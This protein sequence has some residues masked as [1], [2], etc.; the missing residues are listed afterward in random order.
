MD[1]RENLAWKESFFKDNFSVDQC[2]SKYTQK[3]DLETLRRDLKTY[4]ADLHQQ[5]SEIL[6]TETE[7][8]VNLAEYLTNLNSKIENLS[9][10]VNQLQEEVRT[11][12]KVIDS[13]ENEFKTMVN[14]MK[15]NNLKKNHFHLKLGII[16]SLVYIEKMLCASVDSF[17]DLFVLERIVCKYSFQCNHIFQLGLMSED[18]KDLTRNIENSLLHMVNVNFLEAVKNDDSEILTRCLRMYDNL[19]KQEEAEEILKVKVI[20]PFM[21]NIITETNLEK[22][23]QDLCQIYQQVLNFLDSKMSLLLKIIVTNPDLRS[24]KFALNSFWK[25]FDR[26]SREGLPNITAPGNP[27][28]FQKRFK[29]TWAVLLRIAEKCEDKNLIYQDT[30]FQEH[31]KRF[32]LPVYFEIRYQQIAGTFE[33]N[34]QV[35]HS[36]MYCSPNELTCKLGPT[37]GLWTAVSQCFHE[38]IYLDQLADQFLKLSMMLLSRY[39]IWFET[40]IK[41]GF[42]D[43]Q[44]EEK[45][46]M[47]SLADFRV[48]E[49]FLAADIIKF[50]DIEN[51]VFKIVHHSMSQVILR[52][53]KSNKGS[54]EKVQSHLTNHLVNI[55]F[56]NIS[57]QLQNVASI[58]RLY[59]RT[60]RS[61]PK[62]PST[63]MIEA[64]KPIIVFQETF[65]D[66]MRTKTQDI[67]NKV[68]LQVSQ[69]Y[70]SLVQGVLQSVCKTEESLRRL[71]NRTSNAGDESTPQTDSDEMKIREQIKLDVAY[72]L[73]KLCP[74]GSKD[75]KEI[76][77]KLKKEIC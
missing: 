34:I 3:S 50:S 70:F 51:T 1:P 74:L 52:V 76:M 15:N 13:I 9:L 23:N 53:L 27:E 64:L 73:D 54:I 68:I 55:K 29:S 14:E 35:D 71:K 31:L 41:A 4:G 5:M 33:N 2:L 77:D 22:L 47:D 8:I 18:I 25:E 45:F 12:F 40:V 11:L 67:V 21:K 39:L 7:A 32:N 62:E 63:Y 20:R 6:K 37:L 49:K 46:I 38:H 16:S 48:V 56:G 10:P 72:F 30:T 57:S 75:S 69:Q 44:A 60:N 19:H 66:C 24:Y 17:E 65:Q 59:R 61:T 58:P 36:E 42:Q 26:Q 28:L 43:Q